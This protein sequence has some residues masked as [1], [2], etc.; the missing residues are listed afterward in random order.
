MYVSH[1]ALL[2][3]IGRIC[4]STVAPQ[5]TYIILCL[6]SYIVFLAGNFLPNIGKPSPHEGGSNSATILSIKDHSSVKRG[7]NYVDMRVEVITF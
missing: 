6:C 4:L 2:T 1:S 3:D 5:T 7:Q